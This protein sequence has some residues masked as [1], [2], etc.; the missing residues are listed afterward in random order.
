MQSISSGHV[1]H[2]RVTVTDDTPDIAEV[3]PQHVQL[4]CS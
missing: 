3:I 1:R 2:I 4:L